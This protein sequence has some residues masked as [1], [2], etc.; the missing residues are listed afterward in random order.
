MNTAGNRNEKARTSYM[1]KMGKEKNCFCISF[2][3]FG[4]NIV[5][6]AFRYEHEMNIQK[7]YASL[8]NSNSGPYDIWFTGEYSVSHFSEVQVG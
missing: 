1:A 3:F 8:N 4:D 2:S 5:Q 6:F 7:K